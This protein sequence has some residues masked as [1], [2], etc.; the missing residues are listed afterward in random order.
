MEIYLVKISVKIEPKKVVFPLQ[1]SKN[2][3]TYNP[4]WVSD[5]LGL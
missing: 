5:F 3:N 4:I 2:N 1:Q